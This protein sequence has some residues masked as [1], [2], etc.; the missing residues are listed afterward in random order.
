MTHFDFLRRE[1]L[2]VAEA[3]QSG[4]F[5]VRDLDGRL[6]AE[7]KT[8]DSYPCEDICDFADLC[9][10]HIANYGNDPEWGGAE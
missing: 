3:T 8:G 2:I 9:R 7:F 4:G 1:G 10:W 5:L 6:F